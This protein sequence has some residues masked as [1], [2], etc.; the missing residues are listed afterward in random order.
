MTYI[1]V[2]GRER[3][4]ELT[5][6]SLLDCVKQHP[7]IVFLV[8]LGLLIGYLAAFTENLGK[9]KAGIESLRSPGFNDLGQMRLTSSCETLQVRL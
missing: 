4:D 3:L 5:N 2:R 7:L 6:V 8:A 1:T 9:L